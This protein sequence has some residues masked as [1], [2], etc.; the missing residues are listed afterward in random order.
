MGLGGLHQSRPL[1]PREI[2][3]VPILQEAGWAQGSPEVVRK[4]SP[5]TNVLP[6]AGRCTD[7]ASPANK[8]TYI[9]YIIFY[10]GSLYFLSWR[11]L[12]PS[13]TLKFLQLCLT[14]SPET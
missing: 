11:K 10:V 6:L 3:P 9:G 1:Y 8:K 12:I 2:D 14:T 4:I 13:I 5:T 7:W